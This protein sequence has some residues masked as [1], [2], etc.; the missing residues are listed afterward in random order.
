MNRPQLRHVVFRSPWSGLAGD[1]AIAAEPRLHHDAPMRTTVDIPENLH[2]IAIGLGRHTGH[3]LSETITDLMQRGLDA[4]RSS[5]DAKPFGVHGATGL[6]VAR[7]KR[8][9]TADDVKAVE[10]VA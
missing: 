4:T 6:P 8:P 5:V 9:I 7:S 2:R 3:S 10:D 1:P